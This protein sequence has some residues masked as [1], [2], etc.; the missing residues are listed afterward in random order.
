M[1]MPYL[2]NSIPVGLLPTPEYLQPNSGLDMQDHM[3]NFDTET[4]MRLAG[5]QRC[6]ARGVIL[7]ILQCR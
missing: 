1:A 6:G 4:Y 7:T 3:S 5:G 2:E